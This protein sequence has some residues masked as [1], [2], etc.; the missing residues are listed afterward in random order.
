MH[1]LPVCPRLGFPPCF[2][3]LIIIHCCP[4]RDRMSGPNLSPADIGR[5]SE[6]IIQQ[7]AQSS[8]EVRTRAESC[9]LAP[10][11]VEIDSCLYHLQQGD[12]NV[13]CYTAEFRTVVVQTE[14]S[15][16]ALRTAY[17]K[18]LS[19]RLKSKL[20]VQEL[21]ATLEGMVQLVIQVDQHLGSLARPPSTSVP[22]SRG[23]PPPGGIH[24]LPPMSYTAAPPSP[25]AS[26]AHSTGAGGPM[27][28]GCT[29]LSATGKASCYK[30][31]LCAY[32]AI[33]HH[34]TICPLRPEN[35][36]TR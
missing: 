10:R 22:L 30:K 36:Q 26:G 2:I 20:V 7:A 31:G 16:D 24:P 15:D 13:S 23:P 17:Y 4:L 35:S 3:G 27:Q 34:R 25:P 14:L 19:T 5:L 6:V 28:I 32:C 21:P 33:D 12:S 18:G 9:Y 1:G 29:C 11:E 8:P